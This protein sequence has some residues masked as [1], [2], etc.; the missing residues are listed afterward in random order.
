M[1]ENYFF[2]RE[3]LMI[4]ELKKFIF[5]VEYKIEVANLNNLFYLRFICIFEINLD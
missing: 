2:N 3:F 5:F 1:Y 4:L